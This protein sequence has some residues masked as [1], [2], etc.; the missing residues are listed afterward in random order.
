MIKRI[1]SSIL[2][3]IVL[4]SCAFTFSSCHIFGKQKFT[5]YYSEYFNTITTVVGYERSKE[6]FSSVSSLIEERLSEYHMLYDIY[7]RYDGVNNLASINLAAGK[8]QVP[9]DK[10]IIDMLTFAKQMHELTNGKTNIAFGAVLSIWHTYRAYGEKHP[11]SAELPDMEVLL[12]ANEHTAIDDIIIDRDSGSVYLSDS[13]MSLDV[14]AVAKGYAVEMIALEL[15]E[16]G[17]S[18]YLINAGGNVRA[19]GNKPDGSSWLVGIEDPIGVSE[20]G[21]LEY[22]SLTDE[23]LVT[24]GSYQRFYVVDGKNLHHIIDTQTLMPAEYYVSV[25]VISDHSGLADALSTALFTMELEEGMR[26]IESLDS[27]EAVWLMSDGSKAY[28]SGFKAYL[29]AEK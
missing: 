21:Y 6:D 18:G 26:L 14:G 23:A 29:R 7:T 25:S 9:A 20:E 24:S 13:N 16:I 17:I 4:A 11:E 3:A 19:I 12:S 22:L 15:E 1:T 27:V 2:A 28:S 8:S 10:K 5:E